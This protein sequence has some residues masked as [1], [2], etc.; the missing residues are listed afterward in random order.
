[1]PTANHTHSDQTQS[2]S[3]STYRLP[4]FHTA[5]R[6]TRI[7][8]IVKPRPYRF[9]NNVTDAEIISARP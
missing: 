9:R 6:T 3:A 4:N 7:R 8:A 5:L 1:M 2:G